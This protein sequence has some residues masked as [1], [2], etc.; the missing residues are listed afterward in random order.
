[1]AFERAFGWPWLVRFI[2][3]GVVLSLI[4]TFNGNFLAATR[5]LY[6]MGQRNLLGGRLDA[7]HARYGTPTI[8]IAIVG[9]LSIGG[10]F[11]G[12]AA[13]IPISDVGSLCGGAVWLATSLAYA[14]GAGGKATVGARGLGGTGA[15]I[16]VALMIVTA[17]DFQLFHWLTL[18]AWVAVGL[19]LWFARRPTA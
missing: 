8:A 19:V 1:V 18:A 12:K 4:K 13:L 14:C 10:T 2:M 15:V 3:L 9:V 11:L 17:A 16:S 5:M 6:A 7:V